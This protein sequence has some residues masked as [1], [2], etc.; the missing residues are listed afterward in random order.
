MH[1][2]QLE[3]NAPWRA[4]HTNFRMAAY[5]SYV[6]FP[7]SQKPFAKLISTLDVS[8]KSLAFP[9]QYS[10]FRDQSAICK[11]WQAKRTSLILCSEDTYIR[12]ALI[13]YFTSVQSIHCSQ[14]SRTNT[15]T[16][17]SQSL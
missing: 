10:Q 17:I 13:R 7:R 12:R 4:A 9:Y 6:N 16:S 11:Q 2:R 15:L 5:I 3:V 14:S 8:R 1:W